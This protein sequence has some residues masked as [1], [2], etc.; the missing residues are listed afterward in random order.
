MSWLRLL[1]VRSTWRLVGSRQATPIM[2]EHEVDDQAVRAGD[3]GEQGQ[4][5]PIASHDDISRD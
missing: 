3:V 1:G 4:V 2:G 5:E